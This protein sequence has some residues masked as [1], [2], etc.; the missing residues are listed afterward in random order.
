MPLIPHFDT[1]ATFTH[2]TEVSPATFEAFVLFARSAVETKE[3]ADAAER[4]LR[5][6][7]WH[8]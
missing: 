3:A 5:E 7:R 4:Y 1:K 6:E 8:D 2:A